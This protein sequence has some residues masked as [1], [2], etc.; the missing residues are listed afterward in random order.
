MEEVVVF[1]AGAAPS[2]VR[3]EAPKHQPPHEPGVVP[4]QPRKARLGYAPPYE[5]RS[6]AALAEDFNPPEVT[7]VSAGPV[8]YKPLSKFPTVND[9]VQQ[10]AVLQS[11]P[12]TPE[13]DRHRRLS[14]LREYALAIPITTQRSGLQVP[15]AGP[16]VEG[17][18]VVEPPA[19]DAAPFVAEA[20]T[21][22]NTYEQ[23]QYP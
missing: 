16:Y 1:D 14:L 12:D 4:A 17:A 2:Q 18:F 7:P 20:I 5:P 11:R 9:I 3:N 8:Y 15:V 21:A 13:L 6:P 10:R 22:A 19:A 23:Q